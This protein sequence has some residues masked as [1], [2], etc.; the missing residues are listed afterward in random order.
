MPRARKSRS[1]SRSRSRKKY[2]SVVKSKKCSPGFH[3]RKSY[4]RKLR[5]GSSYRTKAGCVRSGR[6][7][8]K[9]YV[10]KSRPLKYAY[11]QVDCTSQGH[12]WVKSRVNKNGY[13]VR[14]HCQKKRS[15]KASRG[16]R[17]SPMRRSRARYAY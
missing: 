11:D 6:K 2:G 5:N 9:T 3:W 10:R 13:K 1:R 8:T 7:G 14:A 4:A 17:R 12:S 15:K 16:Y